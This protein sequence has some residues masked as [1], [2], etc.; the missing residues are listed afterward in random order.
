MTATSESRAGTD[1]GHI[2]DTALAVDDHDLVF[3]NEEAIVA[4]GRDTSISAG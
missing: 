4:I 2:N 1:R 3:H